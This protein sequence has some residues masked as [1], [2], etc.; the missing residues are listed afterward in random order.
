MTTGHASRSLSTAGT[1]AVTIR[2]QTPYGGTRGTTTTWVNA[3]GFV[4]GD[5]DPT[6]LVNIGAAKAFVEGCFLS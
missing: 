5:N 1:Q 3:K 2:R 4:G 6:G